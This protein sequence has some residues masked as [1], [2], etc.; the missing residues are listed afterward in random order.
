METIS[1]FS[2][3]KN[4]V[5]SLPF[6]SYIFEPRWGSVLVKFSELLV[7]LVAAM[8]TPVQTPSTTA[9]ATAIIRRIRAAFAGLESGDMPLA[10]AMPAVLVKLSSSQ[11]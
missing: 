9:T 10:Y 2:S 5:M 6:I 8:A 4:S 11:E 3:E 7:L 1:R